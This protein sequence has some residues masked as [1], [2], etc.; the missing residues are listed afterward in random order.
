MDIATIA[1]VITALLGVLSSVFGKKYTTVKKVAKE[2]V[3]K[4]DEIVNAVEDDKV[5]KEELESILKVKKSEVD[6]IK[7]KN[8]M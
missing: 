7:K 6:E 1:L 8:K 5:T 3:S 4:L 2:L